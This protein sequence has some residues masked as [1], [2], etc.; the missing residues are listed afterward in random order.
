MID[1]PHLDPAV[2][3]AFLGGRLAA[4]EDR[5]ARRAIL[6]HFIAGCSLCRERMADLAEAIVAAERSAK[7]APPAQN[8]VEFGRRNGDR[9]VFRRAEQKAAARSQAEREW[10]GLSP[11]HIPCS[12][13]L[14]RARSE[15]ALDQAR[16]LRH[17]DPYA[18]LA[19]VSVA[20]SHASQLSPADSS[21]ETARLHHQI[22][23]EI[24]NAHRI[25]GFHSRAERALGITAAI[26]EK[27]DVGL[28][29]TAAATEIAAAFL[30]DARDLPAADALF[31]QAYRA[32]LHLGET[33]LAG[34]AAILRGLVA[35]RR[36][37]F[38]TAAA[39][40]EE[41]LTQISAKREPALLLA[42]Y[43]NL[44]YYLFELGNPEGAARL[45][46]QARPLYAALGGAIDLVKLRWLEG[47]IEVGRGHLARA[48]TF[49]REARSEYT[50]L[51]LSYESAL[52]TLD[53]AAIWLAQGETRQVRRSVEE[54][55]VAFQSHKVRPEALAA[56][57]LLG[58]AAQHDQATLALL[59]E[60]SAQISRG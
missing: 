28:L 57:R 9:S 10:K 31:A 4:P 18:M 11:V 40:L 30:K 45:I 5:P 29:E 37:D 54:M 27:G 55:F 23:A 20:W 48:E 21:G 15:L 22:W 38:A 35:G 7:G 41:G 43:H 39:L 12:S 34:R 2:L 44:I 16:K 17:E 49:L 36:Q 50:N 13:A 59:R 51:G 26:G 25:R 58:E 60:V 33:H 52:V 1:T 47:K 6:D 53:L 42:A 24:A 56:L 3:A 19:L 8:V 46:R 32:Y 14:S